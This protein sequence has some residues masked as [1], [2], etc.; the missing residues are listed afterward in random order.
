MCVAS[1]TGCLFH[2]P[3]ATPSPSLRGAACQFLAS[4]HV[5]QPRC[6]LVLLLAA[7]TLGLF[8]EL[9][10]QEKEVKGLFLELSGLF[11]EV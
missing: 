2:H 5:Q 4:L 6:R 9:V 8:L 1:S 11:F 3:Q 10:V 7:L